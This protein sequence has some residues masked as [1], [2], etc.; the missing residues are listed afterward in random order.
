M[1]YKRDSQQSYKQMLDEQIR[2]KEML[3]HQGNMTQMEKSLN[4]SELKAFKDSEVNNPAPMV[5]GLNSE[6]PLRIHQGNAARIRR[7]LI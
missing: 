4:R 7:A 1:K 6:S 2:H 3:K 5:P